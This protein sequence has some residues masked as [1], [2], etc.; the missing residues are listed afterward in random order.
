V[1]DPVPADRPVEAPVPLRPLVPTELIDQAFAVLK[2]APATLLALAA[3][4]VV[5]VQL[6]AAWLQRGAVPAGVLELF[7][8]PATFENFEEQTATSN[9]GTFVVWAGP[10]VTLPLVAAGVA[11]F[12]AARHA[13]R[14]PSLGELLAGAVRRLPAL[15]AAWFLI[16]VAQLVGFVACL[17]PGLL[18]MA[19]FLVTAPAI[20]VEGLGPIQGMRR[21]A[22]LARRRF[23]PTLGFG[24]LTGVVAML[25][26]SALSAA[27]DLLALLFG[28]AGAGWLFMAV[29]G[30]IGS[31]VTMPIVA[32][33]TTLH[34]LD[35][36]VRTEGLDLEVELPDAFPAAASRG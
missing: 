9:W 7:N 32:A 25:F 15:L 5:P 6:L 8:D 30:V 12:V 22:E 23:W 19:L 18:V 13:G 10:S 21:A 27:W 31:I 33:A 28:T 20:A 1:A 34:Y 2:A 14:Q 36:R 26:E 11:L 29:S 4:F 24:L 35:L 16:H 17:F 3:I